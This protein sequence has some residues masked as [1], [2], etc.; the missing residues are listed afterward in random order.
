MT[1]AIQS[2]RNRGSPNG[3]HG[4]AACFPASGAITGILD[5]SAMTN[6]WAFGRELQTASDSRLASAPQTATPA[7]A[8]TAHNKPQFQPP[9]SPRHIESPAGIQC[10]K[11]E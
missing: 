10:V 8:T 11:S 7:G 9:E 5:I 2:E 1:E 3:A 6:T 4:K